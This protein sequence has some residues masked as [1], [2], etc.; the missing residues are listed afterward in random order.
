[1]SAPSCWPIAYNRTM[2]SRCHGTGRKGVGV[3]G[4]GAGVGGRGRG[5]LNKVSSGVNFSLSSAG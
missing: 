3:E 2:P 5:T 1:M 4:G